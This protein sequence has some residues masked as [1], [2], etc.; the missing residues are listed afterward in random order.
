MKGSDM[1]KATKNKRTAKRAST[2]DAAWLDTHEWMLR[3]SSGGVSYGGFR[4][5]RIGRWME[6]PDWNTRPE[7]GG[8]F[9][10]NAPEAHGYGFDYCRLELVETRGQ[11]I[12]I[13]GNKI[14]VRY[15]RIVA[16]AGDIP[17]EAFSRCG[18]TVHRAADGDI[19]RPVAGE[20]WIVTAGTVTVDGQT[21]GDTRAYG[22]ATINVQ[23]SQTGGDTWADGNATIN[24]QASQTGGVWHS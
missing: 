14:K 20:L 19:I 22:N 21:G 17:D 23:A 15:A 24:V 16:V 12:I 18:Y 10:G 5:P 8:G 13:E 4:W 3:S 9:H 6:C 11:R 7:C 1:P 2:I